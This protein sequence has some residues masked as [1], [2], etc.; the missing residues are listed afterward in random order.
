MTAWTGAH[1]DD[2]LS[3]HVDAEL[4]PGTAAAVR[5]HL[6][7]CAG[8]RAAEA[9]LREA[10]ALLRSLPAVDAAPVIEGFLARH[11]AVVRLGAGFVGIAALVLVA[12]ALNAATHRPD[13][14]PDLEALVLA[15]RTSTQAEVGDMDREASASYAAPP[16]LI[17][18]A[19]SLSRHEAY[20]GKDL[21]AAVYRDGTVR[22]SVYQQPGRL[23]W[24]HLPRGTTESVGHQRV[25]F[26]S[27]E[28]VVAV[29][30][31]GDLV[32]TLVSDDRAAVLT[33]VGGLP[34]WERGTAWDRVHDVCQR[35]ARVFTLD[36]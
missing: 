4:D 29:T 1:P 6:A 25:W 28:P 23:D 5:S 11:H 10:R 32:V 7:G 22:L 24:D 14:V 13:V 20:D 30:E 17:G 27:G 31:K 15:H 36:G 2:L 9:E 34:A 33:A 12:L 19:R 16:G 3:A 21:A 35:F 26:R 8:C 18:S